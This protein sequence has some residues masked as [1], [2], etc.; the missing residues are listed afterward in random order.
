MGNFG[1][2]IRLSLRHRWTFILSVITAL[3]VAVLW[4]ANIGTIYPFAE[5]AFQG[6]SLQKWAVVKIEKTQK[7][8]DEYEATA[9]E[10][11]REL[12]GAPEEQQAALL[13][14]LSLAESRAAAE[15]RAV[16]A[17]RWVKPYIDGYLPSRP[18]LTLVVLIGVLLVGTLL[19]C[20]CL[21][22]NAILVGKLS[23]LGEFELRKLFFRRTLRMEPAIFSD[24]GTSDLMSRFTHDIENVTSGLN[25]LFGKLVREPLKGIACLIGAAFIC[26]RL[27]LLT[28]I[29]APVAAWAI[30]WLAKMLKRANR[31]AMEGMAELYSILEETFRG[32]KIVKAF[33]MEREERR[34][35]HVGS[36]QYYK[37][38]MRIARYDS[39]SHPITEILGI[40]MIC[41]ALLA[42]A[43]LTLEG[44]THLLGVRMSSRPMGLG[45][46]LLFYA[47]LAGAADPARKL[48]DVFSRLQR[49]A[50]ASDRIFAMLDRRPR[51]QDPRCPVPLP[52]HHRDMVF[53][54]VSFS[55]LP[56]R[57]VLE[58]IN[59]QI[60]YGERIAIVGPNGCGKST[61]MN[62][63]LRFAD[64]DSGEIR[65]DGI[66]LKSVRM[67]E[68]R[69]QIG[70]VTQETLLFDDTV[71][72]NIRYGS[73][74]AT[75]EEVIQAARQA[76]AHRLIEQELADGY[77]TVVGTLGGRLSGGQ[78][79]RI[80]L[81]RAILRDPAILLLDEATSQVDLE[82]ERLIQK[83]L[84]EFVHDR[85]AVM[86][87]HRLGVLSLADRIV[88]M[89]NGR[90][91]DVGRHEELTARCPL[92][93]RLY[94][95]EFE[96]LRETA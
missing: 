16:Q 18:F 79:Q 62:L 55:Y 95:I 70:L 87:T 72:N 11:R 35:F 37:K 38:A 44:Q 19:K 59:L 84:D 85:T 33:T 88:V 26:W 21:I 23:S 48:S 73:P 17:F 15:H 25:V 57:P 14:K 64:P 4:G 20:L 89:E 94:Q 31:R 51:L 53:D 7:A 61:L 81:A 50:A 40:V 56:G 65:L 36:K 76:H 90:I 8:A 28:L 43:Y 29:V 92:Y 2:V 27:L 22:A 52:R 12:A 41:L 91:Q 69:G 46:L 9:E 96:N 13:A 24:E 82:S 77:E 83:V 47:L 74:Q 63:I 60:H 66:P 45:T 6:D 86:I 5:I 80:A 32:I 54:N 93:R 42:G 39:L 75:R 30:R 71:Y 67:R 49:A 68:L 1:R 10:L 3:G 78:R 34:R 58:G